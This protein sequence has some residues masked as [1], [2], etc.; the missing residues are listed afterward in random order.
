M[1]VLDVTARVATDVV[2]HDIE[3]QVGAPPETDS[4]RRYTLIASEVG[5]GILIAAGIV[6]I[7]FGSLFLQSGGLGILIGGI[8]LVLESGKALGITMYCSTLLSLNQEV[9]RLRQANSQ[10]EAQNRTHETLNERQEALIKRQEKEIEDQKAI[11]VEQT[12]QLGTFRTSNEEYLRLNREL[13]AKIQQQ[14]VLL[15]RLHGEVSRFLDTND[16]IEATAASMAVSQEGFEAVLGGL[17][18]G[19]HILQSWGTSMSE[20]QLKF[21]GSL[22]NL[23][24]LQKREEAMQ[25]HE[26][27]LLQRQIQSTEALETLEKEFALLSRRK[28]SV[29]VQLCVLAG[30]HKKYIEIVKYLKGHPRL[31]YGE[32]L[33]A[34]TQKV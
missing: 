21:D 24:N 1:S 7:I 28:D 14:E 13:A 16:K 32:A 9:E 33:D 10:Y 11:V 31:T 4:C 23:L 20:L 27:E 5:D 6:A 12:F 15:L 29:S 26:E 19:I 22:G 8:I 18:K 2:T 30:V 34:M 17:E 25:K 3:N